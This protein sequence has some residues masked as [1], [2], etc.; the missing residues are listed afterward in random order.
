M[1]LRSVWRSPDIKPVLLS[2]LTPTTVHADSKHRLTTTPH[3][4]WWGL[5]YPLCCVRMTE[6]EWYRR[7]V[8]PLNSDART[9]LPKPL[10]NPD[11]YI[12]AIKMGCNRYQSAIDLRYKSIDVLFFLHTDDAI[13]M[14]RWHQQCDPLNNPHLPYLGLFK[15]RVDLQQE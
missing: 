11:G 4:Q 5:K 9:R 3:I 2:K 13:K 8:H 14:A 7:I 12:W 1:H 6:S 10:I 15:Y